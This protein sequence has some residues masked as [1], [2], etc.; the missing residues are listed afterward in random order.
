MTGPPVFG[1]AQTDGHEATGD[2]DKAA[3]ENATRK[4][5]AAVCLIC[6]WRPDHLVIL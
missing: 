6:R 1:S 3:P 5:R 2:A 4:Q